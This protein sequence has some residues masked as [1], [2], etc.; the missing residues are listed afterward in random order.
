VG[1][2]ERR[3]PEPDDWIKNNAELYRPWAIRFQFAT[4]NR[5]NFSSGPIIAKFYS[6]DLQIGSGYASDEPQY[7]YE[8]VME[9]ALG[10]D[11][12]IPGNLS[13]PHD[14]SMTVLKFPQPR[15]YK[16]MVKLYY[17]KGSVMSAPF[18]LLIDQKD[19]GDVV[20]KK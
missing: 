11:I 4:T 15:T 19:P 20:R 2:V 17:G 3:P 1:K 13:M 8:M 18:I 6:K 9:T 16:M 7:D 14:V 12:G 5:S 10:I